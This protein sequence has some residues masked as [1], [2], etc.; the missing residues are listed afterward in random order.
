MHNY[1]HAGKK[2]EPGSEVPLEKKPVRE[3]EQQKM[4]TEGEYSA[5]LPCL[6]YTGPLA[7]TKYHDLERQFTELYLLTDRE[8]IWQPSQTNNF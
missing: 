6:K 1:A 3:D 8:Q 5:D 7:S 2:L 4:E